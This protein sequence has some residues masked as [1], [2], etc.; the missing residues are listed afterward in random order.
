M[1]KVGGQANKKERGVS[2]FKRKKRRKKDNKEEEE[3][4]ETR[5]KMV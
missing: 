5:E 1:G 4:K 3:L 2:F